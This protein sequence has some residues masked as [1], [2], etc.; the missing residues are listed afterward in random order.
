MSEPRPDDPRWFTPSVTRPQPVAI[1]EWLRR[2]LFVIPACGVL[3]GTL[4]AVAASRAT[5]IDVGWVPTVGD[6][7]VTDARTILGAIATGTITALSLVLTV[8]LVAVQLAAGQ[9]SP[10]TV[11]DYLGDRFQQ[12]TIAAVLGTAAYSLSAL[13]TVGG[14]PGRDPGARELVVALGFLATIASL[15]LLVAAVDRTARRLNAGRL[16]DGIAAET[17]T[18]AHALYPRSGDEPTSP[19]DEVGHWT[20]RSVVAADR[21]GWIGHIDEEALCAAGL[22]EGSSLRVVRPVGTFVLGDAPLLETDVE[23]DDAQAGSL[24]N[25]VVI[26]ESRTMQQDVGFGILRLVDIALRALSPGINDPNTAN[27]VIVRLGEVLAILHASD[28]PLDHEDLG[29]AT[30]HLERAHAATRTDYVA[31]A[32]DQILDAAEGHPQVHATMAATLQTLRAELLREGRA[33]RTEGLDRQLARLADA[34]ADLG[35]AR[36]GLPLLIADDPPPS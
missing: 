32:Y 36:P 8:S 26:G 19:P 30:I 11:A 18:L 29:D 33:D 15:L 16:I 9:L 25:A 6:T 22:P 24:R 27:E 31:A 10:R 7:T 35:G 34:G 1:A 28:L 21:P 23:L 12:I 3:V 4:G 5:W 20:V 2:S 13:R 17:C 14:G